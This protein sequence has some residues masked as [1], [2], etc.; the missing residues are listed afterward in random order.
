MFSLDGKRWYKISPT[1]SQHFPK[2]PTEN[3]QRNKTTDDETEPKLLSTFKKI[4]IN[5]DKDLR[6]HC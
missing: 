2:S 4:Y 1:E 3:H 5:P 6:V